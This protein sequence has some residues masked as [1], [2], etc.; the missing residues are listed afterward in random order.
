MVLFHTFGSTEDLA[1]TILINTDGNKNRY[2]LD[3]AAFIRIFVETNLLKNY[4]TLML[5][6]SVRKSSPIFLSHYKKRLILYMPH[7]E[8]L[9]SIF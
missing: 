2:V 7:A 3:L 9:L 1:V 5:L 8:Y 4:K 6:W